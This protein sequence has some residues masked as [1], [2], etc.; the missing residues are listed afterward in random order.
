MTNIHQIN[1]YRSSDGTSQP[2]RLDKSTNSLQIVDYEHHE[3]H[4][5]SHFFIVSYAD[6]SINQVLDFTFLTPNSTKWVH[7]LFLLSTKSETNWLV[8][9]SAVATNALANAVTILNSNRNKTATTS[10]STLK[11]EVQANLVAANADTDVTGATLLLSGISG[12]GRDSGQYDRGHELILK[13]NTLYCFR[14]IAS[15]AGYI[16]FDMQWYEHT[17]IA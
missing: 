6:L 3:I 7:W 15:V 4:S 2:L 14:A 1:G 8:Y 9:E 12:D 10:D 11:F 16:N 5:G 13:Q 17:D